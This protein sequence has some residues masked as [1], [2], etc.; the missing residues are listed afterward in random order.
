MAVLVLEQTFEHPMSD[1]ELNELH[2]S[3]TGAPCGSIVVTMVTPVA[4]TPSA[5]RRSRGSNDSSASSGGLTF[6]LTGWERP[7][8]CRACACR[9]WSP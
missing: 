5:V 4:N 1:T 8:Q 7:V 9:P 3:P 2:V 6:S